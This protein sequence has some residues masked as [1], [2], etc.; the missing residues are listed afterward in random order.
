MNTNPK[1]GGIAALVQALCYICG[2]VMIATLLNPGD[3]SDWTPVQRLKFV[4]DQQALVQGWNIIIYVV[5]GIAL[6]LLA[7]VLH[8]LL[9]SD[10]PQ[11]TSIAT[12]FG[13]IW[14]GLVIASGM[15]ASVG[16]ET[17][18][19]VFTDNPQRAADSWLVI[20][21]IQNGLGGGVEIVGGIWVLLLSLA[22]LQSKAI[23]PMYCNW[24]G[25]IVGVAGIITIVP[26]LSDFGAVFGLVQI[27]W[28]V[29]VG[30][31]LLRTKPV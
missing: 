8:E 14:A 17:V 22:A 15:V 2:F 4:L 29:I 3:T 19:G 7:S 5:F 28:F 26:A 18:A 31:V 9:K 20:A 24:I 27:L 10:S 16:L 11:L 6:V 25:L 30:I 1:M 23:L 21:T 12:P 13:M